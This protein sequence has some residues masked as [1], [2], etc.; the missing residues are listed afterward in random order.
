[1]P[2]AQSGVLQ[3]PP[4][5]SYLQTLAQPAQLAQFVEQMTTPPFAPHTVLQLRALHT[6]IGSQVVLPLGTIEKG[7]VH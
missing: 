5:G 4:L 1:L 2:P 3:L 6:S 7:K